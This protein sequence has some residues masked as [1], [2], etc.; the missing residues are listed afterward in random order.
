MKICYSC[1]K[2]GEFNKSSRK[3]DGLDVYCKA[4]RKAKRD[5][6]KVNENL[7]SKKFKLENPLYM[8][9]YTLMRKYGI[10]IEQYDTMFMSQDGKCKIC[11]STNPGKNQLYFA[12]DHDHSTGEVRGLLCSNCNLGLGL[13]HDDKEILAKAVEYLK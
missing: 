9:E 12:V 1:K 2:P 10:T 6:D 11:T 13:F 4:C 8:R 7:R 5:A 3:K